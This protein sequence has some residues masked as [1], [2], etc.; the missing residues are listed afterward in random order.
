MRITVYRQRQLGD[1]HEF[2]W[3]SDSTYDDVEQAERAVLRM[4]K[5]THYGSTWRIVQ[6]DDQEA[7]AWDSTIAPREKKMVWTPAKP[8]SFYVHRNSGNAVFVK[9]EGYF[10]QQKGDTEPWG[11]SWVKVEAFAIEDARH[12]AERILPQVARHG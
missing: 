5:S 1:S 9:T 12:L 7:F 11:L 4:A 10:L 3:V 2:T 8:E 6:R